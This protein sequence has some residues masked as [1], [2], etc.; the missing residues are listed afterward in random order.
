MTQ[1]N[2][3]MEVLQADRSL[4]LKYAMYLSRNR[5]ISDDILQNVAIRLLRNKFDF[6]IDNP[7]QFVRMMVFQAFMNYR[8]SNRRYS[9][10][11]DLCPKDGEWFKVNYLEWMV[12][13]NNSCTY[14]EDMEYSLTLKE[15]HK[16]TVN[17]TNKQKTA[18]LS[19][20]KGNDLGED[21][22]V[23]PS[24][25]PKY[26]TEKT[27]KRLGTQFLKEFFSGNKSVEGL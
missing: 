7:H 9:F 26:Q 4:Y 11:E 17:L 5:E 1:N 6:T 14:E 20:L 22:G 19:A 18:I 10:A 15:I 3:L 12:N 8:K 16:A 25:H 21:L 27:H 23:D 13:L 2:L 24:N